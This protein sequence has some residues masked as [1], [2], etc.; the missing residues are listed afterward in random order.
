MNGNPAL[1]MMV[2]SIRDKKGGK[3]VREGLE[4]DLEIESPVLAKG[5]LVDDGETTGDPEG[6]GDTAEY[7]WL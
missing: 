7:V 2:K 5:E 6:S 1:N 3:W 4:Y